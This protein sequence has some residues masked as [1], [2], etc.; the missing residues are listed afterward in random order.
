MYGAERMMEKG[1][2]EGGRK[3]GKVQLSKKETA[4]AL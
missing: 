2:R 4:P 1:K 3:T